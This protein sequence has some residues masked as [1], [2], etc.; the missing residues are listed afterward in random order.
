MDLWKQCVKDYPCIPFLAVVWFISSILI[1]PTVRYLLS[2]QRKSEISKVWMA[3]VTNS[4]IL[5]VVGWTGDAFSINRALEAVTTFL[6]DLVTIGLIY[7]L[8]I[9]WHLTEKLKHRE[10]QGKDW[11]R[12]AAKYYVYSLTLVSA[13][14]CILASIYDL[15]V[16]RAGFYLSIALFFFLAPFVVCYVVYSSTGRPYQREFAAGFCCYITGACWGASGTQI[17]MSVMGIINRHEGFLNSNRPENKHGSFFLGFV[18]GV[19]LSV[20]IYL[21]HRGDKLVDVPNSPPNS[22]A[23]EAPNSP[24]LQQDFQA[25][26]VQPNSDE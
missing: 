21:C 24:G 5:Y 11:I 1:Y 22:P 12:K 19:C 6:I 4:L 20:M 3:V 25:L 2:A 26:I 13:L 7:C 14:T 9:Y 16:I 8:V 15:K 17:F 23:V 18:Q 10:Y